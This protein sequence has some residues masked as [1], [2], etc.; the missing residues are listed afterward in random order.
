MPSVFES[1][2]K[3]SWVLTPHALTREAELSLDWSSFL[4]KGVGSKHQRE[5]L[6][7]G[8]Q[9]FFEGMFDSGISPNKQ[10]YSPETVV[11]Q[12]SKLKTIVKWMTGR[13][14]WRFAQL[15][16]DD[17]IQFLKERRARGDAAISELTINAWIRIFQRMWDLRWLYRGA[18]RIDIRGL[19]DDIKRSVAQRRNV[20]WKAFDEAIALSIIRDALHWIEIHGPFLVD[21]TCRSWNHFDRHKGLTKRQMKRRRST[22]YKSLESEAGLLRLREELEEPTLTTHK[23]LSKAVTALEGAAVSLLLMLVGFRISE[24]A[25]LNNDCLA[26]KEVRG[27]LLPFLNGIAAKK[28]GKDRHWVAAEPIPSI[29]N[30]LVDFNARARKQSK[31]KALF[32]A[33]P[34][35]SPVSLPGRRMVRCTRDHLAGKM[36]AF[37]RGPFRRE[38]P[39][40]CHP[41]MA[42]KT[43]ARLAVKR[44][45]SALEPVAHHLGHAFKWFTD[46]AYV[47]SDHELAEL[48]A[49]ENRIELAAA[50]TDLLTGNVAGKGGAALQQLQFRGKKGLSSL[51][52]S[53]IEKG[54]QLAPCNWGYCIYSA[55]H[56]ACRGD[57]RGPNEVNRSPEVCASCSNFSVTEKHREWWNERA[58]REA[59]FLQTP[60]LQAQAR[61]VVQL[62]LDTS[63]RILR[64][65]ASAKRVAR[66]TGATG[67]AEAS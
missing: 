25:A 40:N 38:H 13:G 17:L 51:V 16:A 50:L 57:E 26:P 36:T 58:K 33:R 12:F 54:V 48:L 65:L 4:P 30:F 3:T 61:K 63:T 5:Y 27:E 53:L 24:L 11:E 64:D 8:A 29:V 43:F 28:G 62:R 37:I 9:E 42:R 22:F 67:K 35:G 31:T 18:I 47:G 49:A 56:S 59:E 20:P 55:S 60:Q 15:S 39:K 6:L 19:K 66:E 34:E 45:K 32:L 7:A 52:T 1:K 21:A 23:V 14:H 10:Q 2:S 44:D 46:G 41:H